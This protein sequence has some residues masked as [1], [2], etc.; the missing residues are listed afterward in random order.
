[1]SIAPAGGGWGEEISPTAVWFPIHANHFQ[2]RGSSAA[3][4]ARATDTKV[5]PPGQKKVPDTSTYLRFMKHS[6]RV[7]AVDC[8]MSQEESL[9]GLDGFCGLPYAILIPA[10][11]N[12]IE[13]LL[14]SLCTYMYKHRGTYT[15]RESTYISKCSEPLGDIRSL[16]AVR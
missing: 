11:G 4:N 16:G 1:M 13:N 9:G 3:V 8:I 14:P 10:P 15:R 5:Y 12:I 6:S 7:L 2:G